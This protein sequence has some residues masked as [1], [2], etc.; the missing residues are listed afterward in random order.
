[1]RKAQVAVAENAKRC[2]NRMLV[3]E[4]SNKEKL[5][6]GCHMPPSSNTRASNNAALERYLSAF[7]G[8]VL[9]KLENEDTWGVSRRERMLRGLI[10]DTSIVIKQA[11]KSQILCV[12]NEQDYITEALST[13]HLGDTKTY[14]KVDGPIA[15]TIKDVQNAVHHF[16]FSDLAKLQRI[17]GENSSELTC[18]LVSAAGTG[19]PLWKE[20][21]KSLEVQ[22]PRLGLFYLN[23]KLHKESADTQSWPLKCSCR[24]I[25][26][27]ISHPCARLAEVVHKLLAPAM[28]ADYISE[29]LKDTPE[30]LRHMERIKDGTHIPPNGSRPVHANSLAFV[31]DVISMY[32]NMKP[33]RCAK[34]AARLWQRWKNVNSPNHPF[35]E[36]HIYNMVLFVLAHS[37]FTFGADTFM[38]I[39]GTGMGNQMAVVIANA[40]MGGFFEAFFWHNPAWKDRFPFFKRFLDDIFGFANMSSSE[41]QAFVDLLN[42]FST[43]AG[44]GIQFAVSAIGSRVP[45]LD[46]EVYEKDGQWH[47][48]LHSKHTNLHA[49]LHPTSYH[50][51]HIVQNIPMMV[52]FRIRRICSE[53]TEYWAAAK[54]YTDVFFARR[55]YP[56]ALVL[57]AF[58][59]AGA[60]NRKQLL[61]SKQR[62]TLDEHQV[63]CVF[64]Y[65]KRPNV[66]AI[67]RRLPPILQSDPTTSLL[68]PT[69]QKLV[70]NRG[71]TI[72]DIL[73]RAALL[74]RSQ[75]AGCYKCTDAHCPLHDARADPAQQVLSESTTVVSLRY[76]K[77]FPIRRTLYLQVQTR[78]LRYYMQ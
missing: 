53:D 29:Y 59:L 38:Q 43:S 16:I 45:Y 63:L 11:D 18:T 49:Y 27:M 10:D 35:S 34:A 67:L 39:F 23:P 4:A 24:P 7:D 69:P 28:S 42:N 51:K 9:S 30:F 19:W 21:L 62:K 40:F 31:L 56:R 76:N 74:P 41:F 54:E 61:E 6:P 26:S 50:P 46:V 70:F 36:E 12:M 64:P 25:T 65:A 33:Q 20:F 52:A 68:F 14:S 3:A 66:G 5:P 13:R 55:G 71:R 58:R 22:D 1:M 72:K 60:R 32:T 47:T 8:E 37:Y 73:V 75:K 2:R 17:D 15:D 48:S 78:H 77:V 57:K 44:W